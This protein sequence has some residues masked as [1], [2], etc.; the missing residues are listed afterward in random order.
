MSTQPCDPDRGTPLPEGAQEAPGA[1]QAHAEVDTTIRAVVFDMD[2]V[3][4]NS[5]GAWL[6]ARRD[7]ARSLGR[8]WSEGR[9]LVPRAPS[10]SAPDATLSDANVRE[11]LR[12]FML[13]FA[14]FAQAHRGMTRAPA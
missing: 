1:A 11:Q 10:V 13:G 8:V 4:L 2:G 9:L 6:Q 3:L 14:A 5:E 12:L 7:Y